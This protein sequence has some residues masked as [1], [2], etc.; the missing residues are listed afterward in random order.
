M[1]PC[2][3][4]VGFRGLRKTQITER[5]MIAWMS[6]PNVL[7]LVLDSVRARNVSLYGYERE[8]T[9]FLDEFADEATVYRQARAPGRW[10]LPSHASLFTGLH[11][12]E[13]GLY[14]EGITLRPD[15]TVFE[16]LAASGYDT[17]VFSYN[18]YI[19]GATPSGLDR[20]ETVEGY[21]DPPFP[22]AADPQGIR[23]Q[24]R[25][26][27]AHSLRHDQPVR[28]LLNGALM[29]LG[30]DHPELL[31][32]RLLRNTSA[33]KTPDDVYADL[34]LDWQAERDGPWAACL[35]FMCTH[36]AY[37]PPPEHDRWGDKAARDIQSSLEYGN[38]E[39]LGEQEPI[40]K[41]ARLEG[42]YDGTIRQ[43]DS[44]VERI[45][46]TLRERGEL[47]DTLVVVTGD[48]GEG[49]GEPDEMR[50]NLPTVQHVVGSNESLLHVPLVVK[51]PGQ[52]ERTEVEGVAS[53]TEFANVARATVEGD[54]ERDA[55]ARE[56][57]VALAST[58]GLNEVNWE[59]M[60][61]FCDG[62]V[63]RVEDATYVLYEDTDDGA[64]RKMV[65]WK[66]R[67]VTLEIEDAHT[68]RKTD[69]D[70]RERVAKVF[71]GL[72]DAGVVA[73]AEGE[74]DAG[75]EARL[76]ALGYR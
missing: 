59:R 63:S 38:W 58:H 30:W 62:D 16:E 46:T 29:K 25:E 67:H 72:S 57:G 40:E 37:D 6:Q 53:L 14:D 4:R 11:V 28:S 9:P 49:F 75:T 41:L 2:G 64:V 34:F 32:D 55:F 3:A 36:N 19:N 15:N 33:G 10:S 26:F 73:R 22:N 65:N 7:L 50:P 56:D 39:F 18:G 48:H 70:N 68:V 60:R 44:Y 35:N 43:A 8:T 20:F 74:V 69:A 27:L 24:H 1:F 45:V 47:E 61:E 5:L 31:P 42:L 23:G 71:D 66:D 21:R 54:V 17:G 12:A 52:T 51:F 13:H 76:E